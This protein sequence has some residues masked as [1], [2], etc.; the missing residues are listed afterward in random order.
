VFIFCYL[1]LSSAED[2]TAMVMESSHPLMEV[3]QGEEQE[4]EEAELEE[5]MV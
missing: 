2:G 1:G 3:F 5:D 4:E